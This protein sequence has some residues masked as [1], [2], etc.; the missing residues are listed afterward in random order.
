MVLN[1]GMYCSVFIVGHA[2]GTY[3]IQIVCVRSVSCQARGRPVHYLL[4]NTMPLPSSS[5]LSTL[6]TNSSIIQQTLWDIYLARRESK[7]RFNQ[8]RAHSC[9]ACTGCHQIQG[10]RQRRDNNTVETETLASSG[11]ALLKQKPP[12]NPPKEVSPRFTMPLH[13]SLK[14]QAELSL[15]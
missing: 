7:G 6:L 14:I 10:R 1:Y 8:E 3:Q 15:S 9:K 12:G 5:P 2:Y 11:E 4:S 13:L